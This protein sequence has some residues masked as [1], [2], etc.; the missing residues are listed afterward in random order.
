MKT[1]LGPVERLG[2]DLDEKEI[3]AIKRYA[4]CVG[5]MFFHE[6]DVAERSETILEK[7]ESEY[8]ENSEGKKYFLEALSAEFA[9]VSYGLLRG[10][11][12][13]TEKEREKAARVYKKLISA[14]AWKNDRAAADTELSV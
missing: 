11:T 5:R 3:F 14:A 13:L 7:F 1:L 6:R 10:K 8:A 4:A 2:E 9:R 12:P